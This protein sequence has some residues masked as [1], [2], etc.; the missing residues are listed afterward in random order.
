MENFRSSSRGQGVWAELGARL[1]ASASGYAQEAAV[2]KK[3]VNHKS[4]N[5]AK[6]LEPI[7]QD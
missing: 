2:K 5:N 6:G 7:I 3:K 1:G 4:A